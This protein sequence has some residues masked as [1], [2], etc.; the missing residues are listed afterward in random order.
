MSPSWASPSDW[1]KWLLFELGAGYYTRKLASGPEA[2][3][4][5]DFAEF[6]ACPPGTQVLDLGCGPGHLARLLA[7]R[8][9]QV[10]GVDRGWRLLRM[11]RRGAEREGAAVRFVR[12]SGERLPLADAAFDLA[13]AT[14]VIY[15]VARPEAV[16]REMVRVTQAGGTVASLDP[17]ASMSVAAMRAYCRIKKLGRKDTGKLVAWARASELSRRFQETELRALLAGAGL[18]Q[19]RLERRMSGL[20]WFSSGIVPAR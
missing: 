2:E 12:A 18:T 15:F 11:A 14:T 13:Y 7:Q 20:V 1:W 16:L 17:H 9:C 5:R 4:R 19:L 6:L 10:T 3:L 8:G